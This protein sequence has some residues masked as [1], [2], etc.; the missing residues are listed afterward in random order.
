MSGRSNK[1]LRK[2]SNSTSIKGPQEMTAK[3]AL[4]T[5]LF[6]LGWISVLLGLIGAVLPIVQTTPFF[7]LAAYL[8]SK[9]S[10]RV[11]S[12]LTSLPYFGDA[13]IDWENN[14][15]IRPKAKITS[16][17]VI[18]IIFALSITFAKI[19]FTLKLMLAC[20]GMSCLAFII[21]RKSHP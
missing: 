16:A 3:F 18:V 11:H 12:W 14:R 4:K 17:V 15:V 13:I 1:R 9:S 10:P 5:I 20:I 19:N 8:F 2:K 21:T 7:I 6:I